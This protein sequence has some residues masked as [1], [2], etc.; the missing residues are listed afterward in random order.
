MVWAGHDFHQSGYLIVVVQLGNCG[1]GFGIGY[2][3]RNKKSFREI[4][5]L[6]VLAWMQHF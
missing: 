2:A 3:F 4:W 1:K 6:D 5:S